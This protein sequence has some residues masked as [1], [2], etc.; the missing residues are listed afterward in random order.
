MKQIMA[1][2]SSI[3]AVSKQQKL[4]FKFYAREVRDTRQCRNF[5]FWM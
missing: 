5:S 4:I 1:F 2:A 3:M